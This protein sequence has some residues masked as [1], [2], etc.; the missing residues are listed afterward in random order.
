M[1]HVSLCTKV[2]YPHWYKYLKTAPKDKLLYEI[3][4]LNKVATYEKPPTNLSRFGLFVLIS[5]PFT[6]F[7]GALYLLGS[8]E[9]HHSKERQTERNYYEFVK[10]LKE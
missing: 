9:T 8:W 6:P 5:V 7:A 3:D 2:K 10:K 1:N 4:L